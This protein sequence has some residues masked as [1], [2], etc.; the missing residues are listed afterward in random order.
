MKKLLIALVAFFAIT[1]LSIA[2]STPSTATPS[3]AERMKRVKPNNEASKI[4]QI[5]PPTDAVKAVE[6]K[7]DAATS[8]DGKTKQKGD[9]SDAKSHSKGRH[10][11]DNDKDGEKVE[12]KDKAQPATPDG[13]V[14]KADGTPD[15]RFRKNKHLKKDGTP[16]K[17]FK[18]KKEN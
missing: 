7:S 10:H 8:A 14:L 5:T 9:R 15:R 2:Q 16:D 13:T 12:S 6:S 3:K 18:D 17:R 11:S 4:D 1:N